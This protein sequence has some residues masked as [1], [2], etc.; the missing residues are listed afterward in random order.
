M[1]LKV[2]ASTAC[3][4]SAGS[5]RLSCKHVLQTCCCF[6]ITASANMTRSGWGHLSTL[7]LIATTGLPLAKDP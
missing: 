1:A 3:V 2:D 6:E 7:I 4:D 5:C